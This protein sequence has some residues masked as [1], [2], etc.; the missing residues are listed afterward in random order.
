LKAD[1][2]PEPVIDARTDRRKYIA[3]I[4]AHIMKRRSERM[5][6]FMKATHPDIPDYQ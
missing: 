5:K 6:D 1:F 4:R 2:V 3:A